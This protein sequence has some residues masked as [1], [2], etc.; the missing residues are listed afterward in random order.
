MSTFA[1]ALAAVLVTA[2]SS[3]PRVPDWQL[4]AAVASERAT[5]A[6]MEG[7]TA[8]A[9]REF[10]L[11]RNQVGS[12]A[13][14]ALAIRIE[15]LRCAVQV[16]ALAFEEC[17][18]FTPLLPDASAA[19]QAYARYLAGRAAPSDAALLPEPQ[20]AVAAAASDAAA[21]SAAAAIGDPLSRMVAAGALMRANRATP[22]LVTTAINT[23]SAQGWRRAVLAWLNVQLQ[24]AEQA[25][26]SAEA[27]RLR[28]RI[29]LATTP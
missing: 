22:E 28:R 12:T 18:G 4:N 11:A 9:E 5:S 23:A 25:G 2:C 16:A 20:R 6:Y 24:R 7:K 3:G 14:P 21:A 26:D 17:S 1:A 13:Q 29:K 8:V 10:G 15:L 27:E 19:D